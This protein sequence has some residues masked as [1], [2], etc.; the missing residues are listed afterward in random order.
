[1]RERDVADMQWREREKSQWFINAVIRKKKYIVRGVLGASPLFL[2]VFFFVLFFGL[3]S[4][5]SS[6]CLEAILSHEKRFYFPPSITEM[7]KVI[8]FLFSEKN[9]C[10]LTFV[11]YFSITFFIEGEKITSDP[12]LP[13]N[14]EK[15]G[16]D[17]KIR[18]PC[19]L[20]HLLQMIWM[21]LF[22][23]YAS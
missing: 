14:E 9:Y 15:L 19:K 13:W 3:C 21:P 18:E 7:K 4:S 17:W 1:M 2:F 11:S 16:G 12:F 22:L 5:A 20:P 8:I 10:Y 23:I 6:A